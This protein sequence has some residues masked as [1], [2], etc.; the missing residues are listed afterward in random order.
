MGSNAV[1]SNRISRIVG[2]MLAT[3]N[4]NAS[5]P[6]LPQRIAVLA[7]ANDANQ[8]SLD[9]NPTQIFSAQAAGQKYGFGS[10]IYLIARILLPVNGG[11]VNGIPVWVYPQAKASG[12]TSKIIQIT[13][14]GVATK[15]G[16]HTLVVAG[17]EGL[18]G[19]FYDININVGDTTADITAKISDA[20]N[21]ILGCPFIGTDTDYAATCISKWSGLTADGLSISVDK[22]DVDLGINYTITTTQAGIGTPSVQSQLDAFGNDWNT[23]VVNSYGAV[24]SV[25]NALEAFNGKPD[26]VNPTGRYR[27]I[28]MKPFIAL[29][30]SVS[31][32]PSSIT[33]SR[34]GEVTIA[35]CPAPNSTGLAMEAAANVCVKFANVSQNTPHLDIAGQDYPDMPTPTSIGS[36]ADYD[37][38]DAIVQK[39]CSTVDFVAGKYVMQ[40]F[41]TTYHPIGEIP[42]QFRYCR[43]IML[44][45][46][47][48]FAYYLLEQINVVDHAIASDADI[49]SVDNVIKPKQWI[50]ILNGLADDLSARSL[51]VDPAFMKA[52]INVNLSTSNPDRLET[53]FKYKRSG[54]VRIASTTAE[55]GFNFGTLN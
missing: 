50:Q 32:D 20:L 37:N 4:F 24:N 28:I 23:L 38:R 12:A 47:V 52:S 45:L 39:G 7:E 55:A 17:R 35:I 53:F 51:I 48:R 40:D 15:N 25:M 11:G 42:P 26:P 8:G 29:T 10:P 22:G 49:V 54:F 19:K 41:V 43:N 3:G 33:D 14:S 21:N 1:A 36:M 6:N 2:Y 46:N 44:D 30:G 9:L 16:T 27:G 18:D 34:S 13:P 31:D 5:S